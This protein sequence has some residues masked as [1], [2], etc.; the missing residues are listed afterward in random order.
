M[1]YSYNHN[2]G[3]GGL[4]GSGNVA[5]KNVSLGYYKRTGLISAE[6]DI[7]GLDWDTSDS[8]Y[9]QVY[10]IYGGATKA[11]NNISLSDRWMR[12]SITWEAG[13]NSADG[14]SLNLQ[15]LGDV[16]VTLRIEDEDDSTTNFEHIVPLDLDPN[17][18]YLTLVNP[19]SLGDD[20]TPNIVWTLLDLPSEQLMTPNVEVV[21]GSTSSS[22]TITFD[23]DSTAVSSTGIMNLNGVTFEDSSIEMDSA[24]AALAYWQNIAKYQIT[25]P[26]MS[27]GDNSYK[28]NLNCTA[29]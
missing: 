25:A 13:A 16:N 19:P 4:D 7:R 22:V 5:I 20:D 26:T 28:I 23:D 12:H 9:P 2:P 1:A 8:D 3:T 15:D 14:T 21:G 10:I 24:E 17:E 18:F 27:T 11:S 29:V 6:F